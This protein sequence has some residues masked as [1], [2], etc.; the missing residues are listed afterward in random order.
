MDFPFPIKAKTYTHVSE[1]IPPTEYEF[2]VYWTIK[3][4]LQQSPF[5][6]VLSSENEFVDAGCNVNF[7][8]IILA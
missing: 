2:S 5:S 3:K 8:K 7:D 6:G 4:M 1:G